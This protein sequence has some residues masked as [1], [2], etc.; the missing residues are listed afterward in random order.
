MI[1]SEELSHQ[2]HS[3]CNDEI[4]EKYRKFERNLLKTT[5]R[6]SHLLFNETS[7]NM[8]IYIYI[9]STYIQCIQSS[10]TRSVIS[11]A[12]KIL[13]NVEN[14]ANK[15]QLFNSLFL[16]RFLR[17]YLLNILSQSS[18]IQCISHPTG[19]KS[20]HTYEYPLK[21]GKVASLRYKY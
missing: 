10:V 7:M 18:S 16:K 8:Y 11:S 17:H 20:V 9:Y 19:F 15:L 5:G 13:Y 6:T 1:T 3:L 2:I 12:S 21:F 14:I 4:R